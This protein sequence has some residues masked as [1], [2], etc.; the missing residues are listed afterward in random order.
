MRL[1]PQRNDELA[2]LAGDINAMAASLQQPGPSHRCWLAELSHDMRTPLAIL[3]G[4]VEAL[5][6]GVRPVNAAALQSL[7][8]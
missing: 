6:D 5:V 3:R 7:Q 2:D 8:E 4:E 1:A